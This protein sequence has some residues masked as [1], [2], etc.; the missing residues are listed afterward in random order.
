MSS[1]NECPICMEV[2]EGSKNCVTTECGHC[3][4]SNCLM[5][6]VA[7]NGFG[8]PYCR[9]VMA[10][11]PEDEVSLYTDMSD[12]YELYDDDALRGL[13]LFTNNLQGIAH[14]NDDMAEEDE[15]DNMVQEDDNQSEPDESIP[16]IEFVSN[17]LREQGFTYE[18]LV[19][20]LLNRDHQE[21]END[22]LERL[23]S[24]VFGKIRIVV[25]NYT[26]GQD[27]PLPQV[28]SPLIQSQP[29]HNVDHEAQPKT[30]RPII[31]V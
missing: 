13:R 2:I 31:H 3:F 29:L 9:T 10:E 24:E 26:P 27:A 12:E 17:K 14:D 19:S 11:T 22:N 7:H 23:E 1:Q 25:S 8:C 18:Q 6:S 21:Y 4:H 5:K 30:R 15:Y 20:C 16:S 28:V